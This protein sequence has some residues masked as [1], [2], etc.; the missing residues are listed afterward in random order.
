MGDLPLEGPM[1]DGFPQAA[2]LANEKASTQAG[3]FVARF[4]VIGRRCALQQRKNAVA[5]EVDQAALA[6]SVSMVLRAD[7]SACAFCSSP[8]AMPSARTNST[9]LMPMNAS[10]ARR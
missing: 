4:A 1:R 7:F 5:G 10:A 6:T 9:L 3:L 8:T 2:A